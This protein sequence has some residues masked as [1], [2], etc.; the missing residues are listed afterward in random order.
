MRP[1]PRLP[2]LALAGLLPLGLSPVAASVGALS[3]TAA[4]P[5]LSF[6]CLLPDGATVATCRLNG[7]GF[8]H[9]EAVRITYDVKTG[10]GSRRASRTVY[11]RTDTTDAG[12]S[13]V[14]PPLRVPLDGGALYIRV[15]VAGAAGDY[16]TAEV[17]GPA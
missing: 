15:T 3:S 8:H 14:R 2:I 9:H 5:R 11:R 6:I 1:I 16:A 17:E 13:F 4:T 12:G 7:H 10:L